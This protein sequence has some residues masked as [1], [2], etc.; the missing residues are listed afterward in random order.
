MPYII[1]HKKDHDIRHWELRHTKWGWDELVNLIPTL[2]LLLLIIGLPTEM[3]M[4]IN[5]KNIKYSLK[6]KQ[7]T[8]MNDNIGIDSKR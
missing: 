4:Q 3:H 5:N 1:E 7:S 6:L 2:L 8:D